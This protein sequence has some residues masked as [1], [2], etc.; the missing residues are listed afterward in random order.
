[1]VVIRLARVGSIHEPRYRIMVADSRRWRNGRSIELLGS[2]NPR[3]RGQEIR[4]K[5]DLDRAKYW[6]QKGAQPSST[7]SRLMK[8]AENSTV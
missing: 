5:I 7:V 6:V 3:P 1:M 8:Q 2:Y 4:L